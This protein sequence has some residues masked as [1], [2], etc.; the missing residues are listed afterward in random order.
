MDMMN[1]VLQECGVL[2]MK[3]KSLHSLKNK[4]SSDDVENRDYNVSV[5]TDDE[6]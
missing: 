4:R 2:K 3:N 5:F 1:E 6:V